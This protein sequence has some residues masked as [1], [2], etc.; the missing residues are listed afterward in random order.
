MDVLPVV[1]AVVKTAGEHLLNRYDVDARPGD[2]GEIVREIDAN[3]E[4]IIEVIKE[5]LLRTRPGSRWAED[6]LAGGPLPEGEWWVV[7]TAEGNI[8][9]IHGMGEWSVTAT[10]VRDNVP[11]LAVV[12]VPL[13]G[14]TYTAVQGGGAHLD[15]V[16]LRVSVKSEL[17]AAMTSSHWPA[18]RSK[19]ISPGTF[20]WSGRTWPI[21]AVSRPPSKAPT[22]C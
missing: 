20:G 2:F 19:P 16:P 6:E 22:S 12:H 4:A 8:N 1:V 11:V 9:H 5:P 14:E 10:L 7:D 17:N 18:D 21:P 13:T 15:G 3:D